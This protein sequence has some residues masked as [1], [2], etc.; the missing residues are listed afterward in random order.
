MRYVKL[1]INSIK[2][3]GYILVIIFICSLI[4]FIVSLVIY[5]DWWN[6]ILVLGITVIVTFITFVSSVITIFTPFMAIVKVKDRTLRAFSTETNNSKRILVP[7]L[8][9]IPYFIYRRESEQIIT[10]LNMSRSVLLTGEAGT[11]KSGIS[12]YLVNEAKRRKILPILIDARRIIEINNITDL[13][14]HFDIEESVIDGI[15]WLGEVDGVWIIVDQFDNIAGTRGCSVLSD[16]L[17]ESSIKPGVSTVVISRHREANERNA[18]RLFLESGFLELTCAN[19]PEDDIRGVLSNV[20]VQNPSSVLLGIAGNLLNLDLICEIVRTSGIQAL[21]D[22]ENN[23]DLWEKYRSALE[24]RENVMGNNQ[25]VL[26]LESAIVLAIEGL[27]NLD[28]TFTLAYQLSEEHRRLI[29]NGIIE[30][31][32][33][34]G[35]LYQFRHEKLQ[36]YLFAWHA[37]NLDYH[38]DQVYNAINELHARNIL[39]WMTEIYQ[40]RNSPHYPQFVE[41]LLGG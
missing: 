40:Q 8:R 14:E 2:P 13:R 15:E 22:I 21:D 28:R 33:E 11:G 35:L 29:S 6:H 3:L 31:I 26:V 37:C 12:V 36:D 41:E 19:I 27:N 32:T 5:A 25:G 34:G 1:F 39:D 10:Q 38:V 23:T 9:G 7:K 20:G 18:L 4:V 30:P 16:V 24:E 17:I